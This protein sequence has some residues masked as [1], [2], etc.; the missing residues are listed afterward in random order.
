MEGRGF[1]EAAHVAPGCRAVVVRGISDLLAGKAEADARGW[2]RHAADAAATFFFE[3]LALETS[4]H[5][6]HRSAQSPPSVAS[7]SPLTED[8]LKMWH[9]AA[10]A[11][12]LQEIK[13]QQADSLL[14]S[15]HFQFS[16]A[17]WRSQGDTL[18]PGTLERKLNEINSE[19]RDLVYTGWSPPRPVIVEGTHISLKNA[20]CDLRVDDPIYQLNCI[21]EDGA[22]AT[23]VDP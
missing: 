5:G 4:R 17:I 7:S 19:V 18:D 12:Y 3:M 15:R 13:M 23:Y 22:E 1:L 6:D 8:T 20:L 2:Q 14:A 9:D 11:R 16:C 10:R 21:R